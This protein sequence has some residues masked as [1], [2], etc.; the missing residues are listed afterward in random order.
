MVIEMVTKEDT[1][2]R[3]FEKIAN[4]QLAGMPVDA[5][6][7]VMCVTAPAISQITSRKDYKDVQ[8]QIFESNFQKQREIDEGWDS[9][10]HKAI[11]GI[12]ANMKWNA[13][14]EFALRVAAVANKAQRRGSANYGN[15]PLNANVGQRVNISLSKIYV[16]QITVGEEGEK[17]PVK[18]IEQVQEEAVV[19][20][21]VTDNL[22]KSAVEKLFRLDTSADNVI[23]EDSGLKH[24]LDTMFNGVV[25]QLAVG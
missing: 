18:Q 17:E 25:P 10:E 4:M 7:K 15:E 2:R 14:P 21:K 24:S 13:D 8:L 23:S 12:Q 16:N 11:T 1:K 20:I 19:A 3:S 5:I 6:A 9:L 22:S